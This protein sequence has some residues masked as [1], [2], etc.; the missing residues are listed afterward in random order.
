MSKAAGAGA[1]V[2]QLA[3]GLADLGLRQPEHQA[4]VQQLL[5]RESDQCPTLFFIH[6]K[7]KARKVS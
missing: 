3:A 7:A 5:L 2:V 6:R 4:R 1:G